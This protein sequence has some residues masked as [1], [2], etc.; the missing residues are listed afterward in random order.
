MMPTINSRAKFLFFDS[1]RVKQAVDAAK[2]RVLMRQ[3]QWLRKVAKNLIRKR[4][5]PSAPGQ[6]PHSHRGDLKRLLLYGYDPTTES[7]VIGPELA[8]WGKSGP[9]AGT[10]TVPQRLEEG[11]GVIV[12]EIF[13]TRK[14]WF[15]ATKRVLRSRYWQGAPRRFRRTSMAARPYMGPAYQRSEKKLAEIWQ[16][17]VKGT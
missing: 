5:K 3:G 13:G 12:E 8:R 1:P 16:D 2:R 4:K 6:P 11:G 9:M 10:G 7:V 15:R 17:S 14:G